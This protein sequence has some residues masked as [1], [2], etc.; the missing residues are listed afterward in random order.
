MEPR[1]GH[2][3]SGVRVHADAKAA[4]SAAA[5]NAS[6]YT[7]GRHIVFGDGQFRPHSRAGQ[8][9][10]AHEIAHTEQQRNIIQ[11]TSSELQLTQPND[12]SEREADRAADMI[13]G[14]Y[15][16]APIRAD[17]PVIARQS[18]APSGPPTAS[19]EPAALP[20]STQPKSTEA[21]DFD[22]QNTELGGLSVGNF[23]FHFK[24][25]SVLISVRVKFEFTKN[26][27]PAEQTSFKARFFNAVHGT[28]AN[29]GYSLS[30][31]PG[32]PCPTVPIA[33]HAEETSGNSY[34]KLVDVER[35]TDEERRPKVISDININ[36]G[37]ADSTIAHEF[38]H[39]LGLY[40][41]YDGGFIENMMFWHKNQAKDK[42]AL[43]NLGSGMR[44]RYFEHYKAA[45]QEKAPAD[46]R[47]KISSPTPPVH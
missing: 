44:T 4:E 47:Y 19:P 3:L 17:G 39:V 26:I 41:E 24:S 14:G 22:V 42:D 7:T 11:R 16:V 25:C 36:L 15:G 2:D 37:S 30:G 5:L 18:P 38:G 43:M 8:R 35:H 6:A 27:K 40:D 34:H 23:D 33:I 12:A 29:T 9:L 21:K 20:S 31:G 45:V 28:W 32:C 10:L 13:T 46:C 1:F